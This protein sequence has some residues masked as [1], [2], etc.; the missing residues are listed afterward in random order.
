MLPSAVA[1]LLFSSPLCRLLEGASPYASVGCMCALF[2]GNVLLRVLPAQKGALCC[3][4]H[5]LHLST[6]LPG[7]LMSTTI[8]GNFGFIAYTLCPK[9]QGQARRS[10]VSHCISVGHKP[11][12]DVANARRTA[13]G[14][15]P[16][17]HVA[18]PCLTADRQGAHFAD[19]GVLHSK[20]CITESFQLT[21]QYW[22]SMT[23]SSHLDSHFASICMHEQNASLDHHVQY[24][25]KDKIDISKHTAL[26]P[27]AFS[28]LT[29][30]CLLWSIHPKE[31]HALACNLHSISQFGL[32]HT[33]PARS[34][35]P[36]LQ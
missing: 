27:L 6:L 17:I 13:L 36:A 11:G 25:R 30:L 18:R 8:P 33:T 9:V 24:A 22:I 19:E 26:V 21:S 7:L 5:Y 2:Q 12:P 32:L 31:P 23:R 15:T 28:I 14:N 3:S 1:M 20:P 10:P 34:S 4:R 35:A 29:D 16:P